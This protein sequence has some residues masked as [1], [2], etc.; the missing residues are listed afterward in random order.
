MVFRR[1][2]VNNL[3][4]TVI[5]GNIFQDVGA[6]WLIDTLNKAFYVFFGQDKW[7]STSKIIF[8]CLETLSKHVLNGD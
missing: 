2:F 8:F 3:R 4:S 6:K 7:F 5:K 1:P